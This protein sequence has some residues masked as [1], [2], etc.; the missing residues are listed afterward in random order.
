MIKPQEHSHTPRGITPQR[1][2]SE[3]A[4]SKND[5]GGHTTVARSRTIRGTTPVSMDAR[6]AAAVGE[7]W[8]AASSLPWADLPKCRR[9]SLPRSAARQN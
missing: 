1:H 2:S 5:A 4:R 7:T 8:L 6:L 9:C 3:T